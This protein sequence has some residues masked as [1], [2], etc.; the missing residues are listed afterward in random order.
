MSEWLF[1][2]GNSRLKCAPL[3]ADGR[4]GDTLAIAHDGEAFADGGFDSLPARID[5]AH[6]ASVASPALRAALLDALTARCGRIGLATTQPVWEG[7]RIAYA[8]PE[9]LG[10]DR[11]LALLAARAR[12]G[13]WLVVG[14]GTAM[15]V[16]LLD[17]DGRHLGGRIA[18]SPTLMREALHARAA[19]LAPV[20][21]AYVEFAGDTPDALASG[22][23]G[24]S[25]AL[26]ERSRDAAREACGGPVSL[27][28]HGGGADAL[29]P[30]LPDA[31]HVPA[32]VLQG[33]ARWARPGAVD[34]RRLA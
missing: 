20:G 10:V 24:A 28:L 29:S 27:V 11:F 9:R 31:V 7:M 14:V 6:V 25:L 13:A 34:A 15:T 3:H 5:A 8:R 1:D 4:L 12:G 18:P 33:L 21:G 16:D 26:V 32:L 17:A 30:W 23:L 19:Q 2:L 22:C